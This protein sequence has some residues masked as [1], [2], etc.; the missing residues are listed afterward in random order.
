M[1]GPIRSPRRVA[2][3]AAVA[4]AVVVTLGAGGRAWSPSAA[5]ATAETARASADP[6]P[7]VPAHRAPGVWTRTHAAALLR[8][9][10]ADPV[11]ATLTAAMFS[12]VAAAAMWGLVVERAATARCV[13]PARVVQRGPPVQV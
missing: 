4:L 11:P 8:A 3:F 7:D 10:S 1:S 12:L 6:Q 9:A 5:T 13:V 2:T